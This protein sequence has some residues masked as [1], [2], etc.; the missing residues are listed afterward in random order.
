MAGSLRFYP[1]HRSGVFSL[2]PGPAL[3]DG[4][5]SASVTLTMT[6]DLPPHESVSAVVPF[7]LMGPGDVQG[8][9][10]GAIVR[11]VPPPGTPDAEREK[12]VH[13]DFA[14]PD[15]PWRY[16]P[17]L[18]S[19]TGLRPWL[20]LVVGTATEVRLQPGG[21]VVLTGDVLS[22][23]D[24]ARSARWA[25]LQ[26]DQDH[27]GVIV[28]RL[29][30]ER[31]LQARTEYVAVVVPAFTE[32]GQPAWSTAS[33]TVRLT[34]F[35]SWRF[36]TGEDGDFPRL[37]AKLEPTEAP[38]TLGRAPLTYRP[39]P[40]A[41]A[42]DIR[43]ALSPIGSSDA[44]V[45]PIVA[46]D[47]EALTTMPVDPRRPVVTLPRYGDCW[48]DDL[49]AVAW[50]VAFRRD[51]RRRGVAGLGLWGGIAQ[52]ELLMDAA[53]AQAGALEVASQRIRH[54]AAGLATS[55]SLWQR[56]FPAD[57]GRRLAVFGPSLRRMVTPTG[58][59]R[60][61]IAG[62]QRPLSGALFSAA[63]RRVLRAGPARTRGVATAAIDPR[64]VMA[65]ANVPKPPP[66]RAAGQLPHGDHLAEAFGTR[67]IDDAIADGMRGRRIS[68]PELERLVQRFDRSGYSGPLVQKL[69]VRMAA[70]V[71][72]VRGGQS[73]PFFTM[74]SILDPPT[75]RRHT[76]DELDRRLNRLDD[77]GDVDDLF[78]LGRVLQNGPV[79]RPSVPV[80]LEAVSNSIAQA[81]DPT[82]ARPFVVDRVL[83][84][85]EGL[86]EQQPLAPPELCPDL[87][88]PAWQFLRDQAPDW[89]L[90][91]AGELVDHSVVAVET[92]PAFVDAYLVGLN[93]QTVGE[94]RFR[95]LPIVTGCT[96]LRQFWA[97]TNP[98]TDSYDDDIVGIATW[99]PTSALGDVSHQTAAA[100][101]ADLVVVFR[102]PL[103]RRF[104]RTLV[105][106]TPAPLVAGQP[107]WAAAPQ[108]DQR[109]LP[110]FQ[111]IL[112]PEMTFFGFD[113]DPAD[114]NRHWVVLEEPPHGCRF[115]NTGP[116]TAR[117]ALMAGATDGAAF[118]SAAFA[119]PIRVMIRGEVLL[120]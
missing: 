12:C 72:R 48:A 98:A 77:A 37:A 36:S 90:P 31:P 87:D 79:E 18:P 113:L 82:V 19:G 69:N 111:G 3:H 58:G 96:P 54:L 63:G 60:E 45:P 97:R 38:A 51:P 115:F 116:T 105:Y 104:P 53:V 92:N 20:V 80:A 35:H 61:A 42:L 27:P 40:G 56:R 55:R 101:S 66:P 28:A 88:L 108:L 26:R 15:L 84:T 24:L 11:M 114:G 23:H 9:K 52:Q 95:N 110:S 29:L 76:A 6:N 93:T 1:S 5:L 65:S 16:T 41:P 71:D 89:L 68:A 33:T 43:G 73:I 50:C 64:V 22:A 7:D 62:A 118:A 34:A 120:P 100:A 2:V 4:R 44:T 94:L 112:T 107:D 14:A 70:M 59:V 8:L 46:S 102:T 99:P 109:L 10:P 91:G 83:S 117:A 103:F 106:L 47:L 86:D 49:G 17:Q 75:G 39:L 32:L 57:P 85:I 81:I 13:V 67:R 78:E 30:C 25:H 21:S 119:D 74:I